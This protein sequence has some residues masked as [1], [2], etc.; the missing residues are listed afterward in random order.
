[1]CVYM[2]CVCVYAMYVCICKC[3]CMCTICVRIYKCMCVYTS[4]RVYIKWN[5]VPVYKMECGA[6][7]EV[8]TA[9]SMSVRTYNVF[10][11]VV[12]MPENM[13]SCV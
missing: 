13:F 2:Q 7:A 10:V 11:Q 5:V 3:V 9:D 8:V 4:V 6:G 1:M 12:Q